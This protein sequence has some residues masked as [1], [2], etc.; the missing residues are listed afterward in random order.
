M[1]VITVLAAM[2]LCGAVNAQTYQD[3][4]VVANDADTVTASTTNAS[5]GRLMKSCYVS[6]QNCMWGMSLGPSCNDGESY[7][8][9]VNAKSGV[10]SIG[11]ICR[12]AKKTEQHMVFDDFAAMEK[13][14]SNDEMI[15]FAVAMEGGQ[16]QVVRFSLLGS[17]AA[18]AA[19][20]A[21]VISAAKDSTRD[22]RL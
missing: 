8:V 11:T 1:K 19:T 16:F 14:S 3:W 22:I 17:E 4:H 21:V 13:I 12:G 20:E 7:V 10:Q 5:G 2:L 6:T 15:G 18:T 9:L